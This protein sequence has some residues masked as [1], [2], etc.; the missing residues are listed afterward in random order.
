MFKPD[1]LSPFLHS[2]SNDR[3][4]LGRRSL[5][6]IDVGKVRT[7]LLIVSG[8]DIQSDEFPLER[9]DDRRYL[10][11]I[12]RRLAEHLVGALPPSIVSNLE[13]SD[14]KTLA[15]A[16]RI[17]GMRSFRLEAGLAPLFAARN[18]DLFEHR[19]PTL[20]LDVGW[21]ETRC[22]LVTARDDAIDLM[23]DQS[24]LI[25]S[26]SFSAQKMI[27]SILL[28]MMEYGWIED[29]EK[30]KE[31]RDVYYEYAMQLLQTKL[32]AEG[33][34]GIDPAAFGKSMDFF[35]ISSQDLI[36]KLLG[37]KPWQSFREELLKT[38][39]RTLQRERPFDAVVVSG[40]V[41]RLRRL[42][43]RL[44]KDIPGN[45]TSVTVVGEDPGFA[46]AVGMVIYGLL[47]EAETT[48][49]LPEIKPRREEPRPAAP[50]EPMPEVEIPACDPKGHLEGQYFLRLA[51]ELVPVFSPTKDHEEIVCAPFENF[52]I[53][54]GKVPLDLQ[55]FWEVAVDGSPV[56]EWP[57]F[58]AREAIDV[59][60]G[61]EFTLLLDLRANEEG[62]VLVIKVASEGEEVQ[63]TLHL[64][65]EGRV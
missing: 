36:K 1:E 50:P 26:S 41:C 35:E 63:G 62:D 44:E 59:P 37:K 53:R 18:R 25:H 28:F 24:V 39:L 20:L 27:Y 58:L 40:G 13:S 45:P 10:S 21:K 16:L 49:D 57:R 51:D 29:A 32:G 46:G 34:I 22:R 12:G 17:P 31:E 19:K 5:V 56:A 14:L 64:P 7:K 52:L 9:D 54:D 15:S 3:K 42:K 4:V 2:R 30:S 23:S 43:R 60:A 33:L 65:A 48:E 11:S 6:G 8:G 47:K 55:V 61:V 38:R